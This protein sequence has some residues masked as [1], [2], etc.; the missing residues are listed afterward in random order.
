MA[1]T[2]FAFVPAT[3]LEDQNTYPTTP[4]TEEDFRADLMAPA[5][6]V[7]AFMNGGLKTFLNAMVGGTLATK[8]HFEFFSGGLDKTLI[9]NY[10]TVAVSGASS[11]TISFE[12]AFPNACLMPICDVCKV[13]VS[14]N[15]AITA[16]PKYGWNGNSF[17][18]EAF[19]VSAGATTP[20]G[21]DYI[22]FVAIGY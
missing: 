3:G 22:T 8:G 11:G 19:G 7:K 13:A 16:R 21:T 1:F 14:G 2:D 4:A 18:W 9:V 12:K 5:N 10:G 17:D 20:M 15:Y 6:Q